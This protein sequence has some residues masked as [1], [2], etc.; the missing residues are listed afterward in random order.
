M[1]IKHKVDNDAGC[2]STVIRSFWTCRT[3]R[4]RLTWSQIIECDLRPLIICRHTAW[5]SAQDRTQLAQT[6]IG[7]TRMEGRCGRTV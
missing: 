1:E 4:S 2:A 7:P 3:G 5:Q 6:A